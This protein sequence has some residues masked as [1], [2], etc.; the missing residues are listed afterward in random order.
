M[1]SDEP[2]ERMSQTFRTGKGAPRS[3]GFGFKVLVSIARVRGHGA[4]IDRKDPSIDRSIEKATRFCRNAQ[5]RMRAVT[6]FFTFL[7][8]KMRQARERATSTRAPQPLKNRRRRLLYP[9]LARHRS[10]R[11]HS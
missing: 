1:R 8:A 7:S 2:M 4:R 3:L 9:S 6:L 10:R 5:N 11:R